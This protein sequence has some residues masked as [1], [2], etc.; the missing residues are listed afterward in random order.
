MAQSRTRTHT[1]FVLLPPSRL[2]VP[3]FFRNTEVSTRQ[4]SALLGDMQRFRGS[5]YRADGAIPAEE[6]TDDG[7]H[8]VPIDEASW[9]ILSLNAAG[10][11]VA[12]V[13]YLDESDASGFDDLWVRHSAL[14]GCP[15][16]GRQFRRAVEGEMDRARQMGVSFSEVGG[17][18]VAEEYRWTLEPLRIV[19]ATCGL[20]QLLGGTRGVAT[21]TFRHSSAMILR[22]I[23]LVSIMA[24][25]REIPPYYDPHYRCQMEVL[26]FDSGRPNPRYR[27][28]IAELSKLLSTVPVI[29]RGDFRPSVKTVSPA[30]ERSCEPVLMPLAV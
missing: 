29:A 24:D 30:F 7:R 8:W 22:R 10:Q 13:R 19:L 18:A 17:W 11:V 23:G 5:I 6:L 27:H 3:S 14:A 26:R 1:R 16:L 12:C 20:A 2:A 25:D 28:H 15:A 4:Y 9:H 21:A